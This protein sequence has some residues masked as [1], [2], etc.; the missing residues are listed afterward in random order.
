MSNLV[1]CTLGSIVRSN[2]ISSQKYHEIHSIPRPTQ[3]PVFTCNY[4]EPMK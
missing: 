4:L 1:G 3:L 2:N